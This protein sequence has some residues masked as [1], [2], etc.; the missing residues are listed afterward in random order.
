MKSILNKMIKNVKEKVIGNLGTISGFT[1]LLSSWQICH[2]VCLG[3]VSVLAVI[4]I[5][6][7][8]MPFEILTR[9]AVPIWIFAFILL[10][11]TLGF[12]LKKKCISKN[13]L[14]FNSG[15]IVASVPFAVLQPAIAYFWAIGGL[16]VARGTYG[17]V[18]NK[19]RVERK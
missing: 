16:F 3:I 15:L 17:Y 1:S 8:F 7:N 12:Y 13:Q 18:K 14:F 19:I 9:F 6:L 4:G 2:N 5:T 10:L 11:V